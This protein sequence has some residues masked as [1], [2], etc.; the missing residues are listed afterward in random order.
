MGK[1]CLTC[2]VTKSMNQTEL[3]K[4]IP[5]WYKEI[6]NYSLLPPFLL[7]NNFICW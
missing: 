5:N 4:E 6:G 7:I 2:E 1:I 3:E